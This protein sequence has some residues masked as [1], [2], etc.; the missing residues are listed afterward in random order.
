MNDKLK[1]S[2]EAFDKNWETRKERSYVHWTRGEPENQIQLA[3][4]Q[5]WKVF[6]KLLSEYWST[7]SFE[8][9]KALEV[10]C[11]R[12][13]MSM[14]FCDSGFDCTLLDSSEKVIQT[15]E[16]LFGDY[17]MQ[18][19]FIVGNGLD[20]PFPDQS[21]DV[22]F[23]IGLLEHFEDIRPILAEQ[24]R[25][26]KQNGVLLVYVVPEN[27]DNIQKNYRWL[28]DLLK[29]YAQLDPAPPDLNKEPVYRS[30]YESPLYVKTLRE[31]GLS[32]VQVSGLYP[33]PMISPS[34][35]FPFTLN[36]PEGEK[37]LVDHFKHLLKQREA[38]MGRLGWFC[39]EADG[40]AFLV[41]G[42]RD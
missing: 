11:G 20:L 22:V 8:H 27:L 7:T 2:V 32:D 4:Q 17:N 5:H 21:F 38:E 25:M 23:S 1:G 34:V 36:V 29:V 42:K 6:S 13:T 39:D 16:S 31:I 19:D 41:W 37:I 24:V 12:G 3:F 35:D 30:D 9:K 15:A 14:F 26:L 28:N 18:A 40:Q 10:G 33:I